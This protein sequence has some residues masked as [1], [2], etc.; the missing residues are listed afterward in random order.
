MLSALTKPVHGRFLPL[1]MGGCHARAAPRLAPRLSL[2]VRRAEAHVARELGGAEQ[3]APERLSAARVAE[4][5]GA[6]QLGVGSEC[7]CEH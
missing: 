3:R 5:Q 7:G 1:R 2:G 4:Q 6:R